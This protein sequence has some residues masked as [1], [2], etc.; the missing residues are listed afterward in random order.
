M[1]GNLSDWCRQLISEFAAQLRRCRTKRFIGGN[2]YV[3]DRSNEG[4]RDISIVWNCL[5][6]TAGSVCGRHRIFAVALL[7]K[8]RQLAADGQRQRAP[9][10]SARDT[11]CDGSEL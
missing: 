8:L 11:R 2:I 7:R 3:E 1:D 10:I 5:C 4:P 6:W 9:G